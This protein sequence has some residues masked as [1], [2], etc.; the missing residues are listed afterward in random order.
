MLVED[1]R[2]GE[3]SLGMIGAFSQRWWEREGLGQKGTGEGVTMNGR[4]DA[5]GSDSW[6]S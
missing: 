2:I 5:E 6:G 3:E 4:R 1:A